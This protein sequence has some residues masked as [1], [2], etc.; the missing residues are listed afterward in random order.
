M[1]YK[2]MYYIQKVVFVASALSSHFKE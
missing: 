2:T 1:T